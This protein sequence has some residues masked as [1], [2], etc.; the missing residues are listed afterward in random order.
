MAGEVVSPL[1]GQ[2]R[3]IYWIT[4][5][6]YYGIRNRKGSLKADSGPTHALTLSTSVLAVPLWGRRPHQPQTPH[7]QDLY[8]GPRPSLVFQRSSEQKPPYTVTR[9]GDF[10]RW[11]P[12][13]TAEGQ[14][15]GPR[16]ATGRPA[17]SASTH[18]TGTPRRA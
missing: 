13:S 14:V 11:M 6:K 8:N 12:A 17:P 5:V 3:F 10:F 9:E 18:S 16:T 4:R 1:P 7:L 15:T 2:I